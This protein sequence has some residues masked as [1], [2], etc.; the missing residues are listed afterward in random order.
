MHSA[1]L[2]RAFWVEPFLD[3]SRGLGAPIQLRLRESPTEEPRGASD[4]PCPSRFVFAVIDQVIQNAGGR[5]GCRIGYEVGQRSG[6][7]ALNSFGR[8]VAS[9]ATLGDAIQTAARLMPSIHSARTLALT[10]DGCRARLSSTLNESSLS[11][12]A[13]EDGFVLSILIE[14]VRL[15]AGADWRPKTLSLQSPLRGHERCR[16]T[17]GGAPI[18]HG[19]AATSIEF[20]RELLDRPLAPGGSRKTPTDDATPLPE[21]YVERVRLVLEFLVRQGDADIES[22]AALIGTSRRS[23]QRHLLKRGETFAGMLDLARMEMA[24][25]MLDSSSA[26]VIDIAFEVGYSDPSHFSRAFRRWTGLAPGA[27]RK[28]SDLT[29]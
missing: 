16:G 8:R 5:C 12:T 15:A 3:Y 25:R 29:F 24:R 21:E 19:E 22:L 23:L 20:P 18:R 1:P 13:W 7:R 27:F 28:G 6:L 2:L 14:I 9:Q 10:W 4:L 26:K 11:P 17:L